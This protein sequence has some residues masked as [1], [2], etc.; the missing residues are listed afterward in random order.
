M[1]RTLWISELFLRIS[2][3]DPKLAGQPMKLRYSHDRSLLVFLIPLVLDQISRCFVLDAWMRTSAHRLRFLYSTGNPIAL[4]HV[5]QDCTLGLHPTQIILSLFLLLHW[6]NYSV[7]IELKEE[8]NSSSFSPTSSPVI[9]GQRSAQNQ[10]IDKAYPDYVI[11]FRQTFPLHVYDSC[12]NL[13][14]QHARL[15]TLL[16]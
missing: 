4:R 2:N 10:L 3:R 7:G 11:F 5:L 1:P 12:W 9:S 6:H 16:V 14:L 15:L 8:E 13:F